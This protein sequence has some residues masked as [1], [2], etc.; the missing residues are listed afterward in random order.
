MSSRRSRSGGMSTRNTLSR[1]KRS[2]RNLPAATGLTEHE[3][4]LVAAS[5]HA[6]AVE[7]LLVGEAL[8]RSGSGA[9]VRHRRA[10]G[11][12]CGLVSRGAFEALAPEFE[13]RCRDIVCSRDIGIVEPLVIFEPQP[14][15]ERE[16]DGAEELE[17]VVD[18]AQALEDVV[19]TGRELRVRR[20]RERMGAPRQKS[21]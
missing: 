17:R 20:K 4:R 11:S 2:S 12:Q 15:L 9:L 5:G 18:L 10:L 13:P 16:N 3:R 1:K 8:G 19:D 21:F 6:N 7:R 14:A